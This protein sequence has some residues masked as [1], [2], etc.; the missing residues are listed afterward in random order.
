MD[1]EGT[2]TKR[3]MLR[4]EGTVFIGIKDTTAYMMAVMSA[5]QDRDEVKLKARGKSISRAVDVEQRMINQMGLIE[6]DIVLGTEEV[7]SRREG[8]EGKK[9]KVSSIEITLAKKKG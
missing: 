4:E 6:G 2:E 1:E 5:L 7:E 8:E 9:F 3:D